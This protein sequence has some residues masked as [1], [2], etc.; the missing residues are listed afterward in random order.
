V[1]NPCFAQLRPFACALRQAQGKLRVTTT[2]ADAKF[3]DTLQSVGVDKRLGYVTRLLCG[4]DTR[5]EG[6]ETAMRYAAAQAAKVS[7]ACCQSLLGY[8]A[9]AAALPLI[10]LLGHGY[11][12][13]GSFEWH[14]C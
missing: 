8:F 12:P 5:R 6:K 2:E 9:L 3:F 14:S 11:R 1:K 4:L 13:P 10:D 7:G